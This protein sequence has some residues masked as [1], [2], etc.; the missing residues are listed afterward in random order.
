[1][2]STRSQTAQTHIND[3]LSKCGPDVHD[4]G[5][6]PI[7][8]G[9]PPKA[10]ISKKRKPADAT[11]SDAPAPAPKRTK[12]SQTD[13]TTQTTIIINRAPVL[14]LWS[15][16]V[17]HVVHPEL[18]WQT[19]LSAGSAVSTICAA[20]KGRSVGTVPEKEESASKTSRE[21]FETVQVMHFSLRLKDGLALVG[22]TG[23][24]RPAGEDG[25]RRKFGEVEYERV[26]GVFDEVLGDWD[27]GPDELNP[28]A[29]EFYEQ[30]RP[31]VKSGQK[32]WGR[33]GELDLE[34]VKIVVAG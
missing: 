31:E 15:A 21:D 34:K 10:N 18:S 13:T 27:V 30:F 32:G 6:Q 19:C 7:T 4:K 26:R 11:S 33:K 16:C 17:A 9:L 8:Q 23:K 25:L 20:A 2:V 12:P 28:K 1:M 22:S 3:D 5:R 29:F 14:H 24:G